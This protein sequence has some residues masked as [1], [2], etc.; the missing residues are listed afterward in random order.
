M[1]TWT[2]LEEKLMKEQYPTADLLELADRLGRS[3]E[4]VRRKATRLGLRRAVDRSYASRNRGW[5]P[6][7]DAFMRA[8][9]NRDM[10]PGEIAKKLGRTRRAVAQH[11]YK[12][13]LSKPAE[14]SINRVFNPDA[15]LRLAIFTSL[16]VIAQDEPNKERGWQW[17]LAE[18]VRAGKYDDMRVTVYEGE[19]S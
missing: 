6:E 2:T 14:K 18:D 1:R 10:T 19:A 3:V 11:A 9:Y 17:R 15:E 8:H 5:T 13:G 12:T 7:E 16:L 4:G